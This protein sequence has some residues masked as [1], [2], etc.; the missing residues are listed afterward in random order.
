MKVPTHFRF[1]SPYSLSLSTHALYS[2]PFPPHKVSNTL[3]LF[4]SL[5]GGVSESTGVWAFGRLEEGFRL[6]LLL[7]AVNNLH[8]RGEHIDVRVCDVWVCEHTHTHT[9]AHSVCLPVLPNDA[10]DKEGQTVLMRASARET[11]LLRWWCKCR[12]TDAHGSDAAGGV[13]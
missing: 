12:L 6:A 1:L 3:F 2:L 9:H 4:L 8:R 13:V 7:L 11:H 10:Q 5:L